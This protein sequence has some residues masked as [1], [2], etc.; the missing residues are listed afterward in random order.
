VSLRAR[1]WWRD[2]VEG[3][4]RYAMTRG[5]ALALLRFIPSASV[6]AIITDQPYSSGGLTRGDRMADPSVKYERNDVRLSRGEFSGDNRDQR[7]YAYWCA[8]W[9]SECLRIAKPGAPLCMFTDW[10]QLPSTTDAVQAGGWIWRGI[11]PWDKTEG[12]RPQMGRFSAQCEYIVWGSA[13]AMPDRLEIGCL[14][15]I[16]RHAVPK[17]LD[18][19]HLTGKPTKVMQEIARIADRGGILLDPFAGSGTTG[20]G[21]LLEGRRFLGIEIDPT[22]HATALERL[23]AVSANVSLEAHRAGQ[24]P[25]LPT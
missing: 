19:H 16:T 25:L 1:D 15:G 21:A 4:A 12:V 23:E 18:K 5:E 2:V 20:I 7:S 24:V 11:V 17:V 10:R 14:P 9:L 3:P 22:H 6:D 13:G 8:L